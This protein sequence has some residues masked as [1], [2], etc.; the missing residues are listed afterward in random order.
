MAQVVPGLGSGRPNR[1]ISIT[2]EFGWDDLAPAERFAPIWI[3][4]DPGSRAIEGTVS[5]TVPQ[6]AVQQVRLV[7]PFAAAAGRATTIEFAASLPTSMTQAVVQVRDRS[8]R[9]VASQ[10]WN[11]A[12]AGRQQMLPARLFMYEDVVVCVGV[13][14]LPLA[15]KAWTPGLTPVPTGQT[16]YYSAGQPNAT[17]DLFQHVFAVDVPADEL[18]T[19]WIAYDSLRC[20]VVNA[21]ATRS[22]SPAAAQA[23]R[24][25]VIDGGR[26]VVIASEPGAEWVSWLSGAGLEGPLA[27]GT[28]SEVEQSVLAVEL[29][30]AGSVAPPAALSRAA[31]RAPR[32]DDL[33][34]APLLVGRLSVRPMVL[35]ERGKHLGWRTHWEITEEMT[36]DSAGTD[37]AV[38]TRAALLAEGPLGLGFV[39]IV[40]FDP[41]DAVLGVDRQAVAHV[42][43]QVLAG[44][45]EPFAPHNDR[46]ETT[47]GW[48]GQQASGDSQ[49][50]RQAVMM[51]LDHLADVR[52]PSGSTFYII[53]GACL[54]LALLIGPVDAVVLKRLHLRPLAWATALSWIAMASLASYVIPAIGE[55]GGGRLGRLNVIDQVHDR[56]GLAV[57]SRQTALT[58]VF[59]GRAGS[60]TLETSD[61]GA[62]WRGVSSVQ[63]HYYGR[64]PRST[65]APITLAVGDLP[66]VSTG[67]GA[68]RGAGE[69]LVGS[70]VRGS[71]PR[72]IPMAI[73]TFRTLMERGV[74]NLP[75]GV[76]VSRRADDSWR[77][78]VA[79]MPEGGRILEA[80]LAVGSERYPLTFG[81]DT[82]SGQHMALASRENDIGVRASAWRV[83]R[84]ASESES[85]PPTGVSGPADWLNALPGQSLR[86]MGS[87][88]RTDALEHMVAS[89]HWAVV[90]LL[91][92]GAPIDAATSIAETARRTVIARLAVPLDERFETTR[93]RARWAPAASVLPTQTVEEESGASGGAEEPPAGGSEDQPESD[94][95]AAPGGAAIDDPTNN[96]GSPKAKAPKFMMH[97]GSVIA[98]E[99][100]SD[101]VEPE[102]RH[103]FPTGTCV[104]AALH[105][106]TTTAARTLTTP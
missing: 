4:I 3:T 99:V 30:D 103:P 83:E 88:S 79:G 11:H 80:E 20:L 26:L 38:A 1:G 70:T 7:A 104:R 72:A 97:R 66:R 75:V 96:P 78:S 43:K 67:V 18:P 57:L 105:S 76:Q 17:P 94:P 14:G 64:S 29:G 48:W 28:R 2:V 90:S 106:P 47:P 84:L 77:V 16:N 98:R 95:E 5:L 74:G 51:G 8:G 50:A 100:M 33:P 12:P 54:A 32:T 85:S 25:W 86:L 15:A 68:A 37:V 73:Y 34:N 60:A 69:S 101:G 40:G 92:E 44:A 61:P 55:Q 9:V 31:A 45:L 35:T 52:V 63:T 102:A 59:S 82:A 6:D 24:D 53:A 10:T 93:V 87:D 91:I 39:T 19:A 36:A 23:I 58:G 62:W 71:S 49:Q 56:H 42:W 89:G 81:V 22:I 46:R 21:G 27:S 13:P 65:A 41:A